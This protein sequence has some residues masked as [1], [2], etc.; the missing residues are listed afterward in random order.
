M[1]RNCGVGISLALWIFLIFYLM[2][3][4]KKAVEEFQKTYQGEFNESLSFNEAETMFV[5][6]IRF[7]RELILWKGNKKGSYSNELRPLT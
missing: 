5:E 1:L 3:L 2:P 6:L 7:F 4:P